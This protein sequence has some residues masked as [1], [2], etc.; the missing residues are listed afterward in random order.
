MAKG[1]MLKD[2]GAWGDYPGVKDGAV[3][4]LMGT[5]AGKEL[6]APQKEI[7]FVEDMTPQERAAAL[8]EKTGVAIPAGLENLGNTC[9]MNSVIQCLKRVN[10]LKD[11]L[12]G[13]DIDEM[14]PEL[15]RDPNVFL[16]L[17][18]KKVFMDLDGKGESFPPYEFV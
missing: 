15:Q 18:A 17:A 6:K 1:K 13:F 3:L 7:K 9:Y 5:A 10:E 8:R 2:D 16:T 14:Q 11:R 4:M 12:K